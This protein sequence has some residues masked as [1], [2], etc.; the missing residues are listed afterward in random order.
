MAV[1][2]ACA[3]LKD[4]LGERLYTVSLWSGLVTWQSVILLAG[5]LVVLRRLKNASAAW[6]PPDSLEGQASVAA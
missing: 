4:P 5:C 3:S 2:L 1:A 6:G